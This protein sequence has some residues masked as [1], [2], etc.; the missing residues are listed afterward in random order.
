VQ[1]MTLHKAK[2]LQFD[3]VILPALDLPSG[4]GDQPVLRWKVRDHEGMRTLVLA[5]LRARIGTQSDEEPVYEWLRHLDGA[6]E[7]AELA[8]LLYVGATRPRRRL[9]LA[10]VVE[11]ESSANATPG[12]RRPARGTALE[13]LWNALATRLP[14]PPNTTVAQETSRVRGSVSGF[15]RLPDTWR[16]PALPT[17]LPVARAPVVPSD[18]PVFDWADAIAAAIGTV[19]HRL[20]AQLAREGL[21]AWTEE[22]VARE[23][24]RIM[25]ELAAEGIEPDVREEAARRVA[26]VVTRTLG[27][28]RG[29]W[30]FDPAHD[31]ARS[32]WALAGEDGGRIVHV[33]LDRSFVCDGVRYIVD[34]KTGAHLGGDAGAFLRQ[35]FERYAPQLERYARIVAAF[36]TRP[37]RIALYHPLVDGGWQERAFTTDGASVPV[38]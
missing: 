5:P 1:I 26:R 22:R 35:E 14:P 32:E 23:H 18:A 37:V 34:F 7:A 13:R 15:V 36:D 6:E 12:W 4:R 38:K 25:A 20:F 19:A 10:A 30:L 27:D 17:P 21:A 31:D 16:L 9:H 3:A 29:R 28:A 33:V 8:R 11:V 2:G 24:A